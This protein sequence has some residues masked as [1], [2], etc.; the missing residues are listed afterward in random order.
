[1]PSFIY[2][3]PDWAQQDNCQKLYNSL[4]YLQIESETT[5]AADTSSRSMAVISELKKRLE[6]LKKKYIQNEID[7]TRAEQAAQEAADLTDK[8]EQVNNIYGQV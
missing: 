2:R 5:A 7:V 4:V 6:A 1:M 3:L 8:A